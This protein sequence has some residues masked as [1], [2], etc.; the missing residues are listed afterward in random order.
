[1]Q[2]STLKE[3]QQNG[4]QVDY[5]VRKAGLPIVKR[6]EII[7]QKKIDEASLHYI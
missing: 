5:P 7:K 6:Y 1:M 2:C 4:V 3:G